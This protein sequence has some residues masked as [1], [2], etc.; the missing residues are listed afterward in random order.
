MNLK[1]NSIDLVKKSKKERK[2][3]KLK[4]LLRNYD[5]GFITAFRKY[6][7]NYV[8]I[9]NGS[10]L[11]YTF[12]E[13]FQRNRTLFANLVPDTNYCV[14]RVKGSYYENYYNENAKLHEDIGDNIFLVID[15]DNRGTLLTDLIIQGRKCNQDNILYIPKSL[16]LKSGKDVAFLIGTNKSKISFPGYNKMIIYY[17]VDWSK[18][19]QFYTK[20]ENIITLDF[21]EN[22]IPKSNI[23]D[24]KGNS[25]LDNYG[26]KVI[27][28]KSAT[29]KF[30]IDEHL[31]ISD[32]R[33]EMYESQAKKRV[34]SPFMIEEDLT[35]FKYSIKPT[36]KNYGFFGRWGISSCKGG[37]YI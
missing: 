23:S 10:K 37:K 24:I 4:P 12:E 36:I 35:E 15:V 8:D 3:S 29:V 22:E 1:N 26:N 32:K 6:K 34:K 17:G 30:N 14:K 27:N 31:Q 20:D 16:N 18:I 7:H 19:G 21:Q 13:N 5:C 33:V 28:T 25:L 11:E 2:E 9:E